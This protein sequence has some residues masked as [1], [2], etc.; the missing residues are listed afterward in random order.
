MI[1][2]H[3]LVVALSL[4]LPAA[5]CVHAAEPDIG[6]DAAREV[7]DFDRLQ[8]TA[9]RTQRALVD[10]P[11]TVDVIDREQLDNQLVRELRTCSGIRPGWR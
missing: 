3:P 8:V 4:A 6:G 5:R 10:V 11:A 2:L 7:H 9:T 1:R